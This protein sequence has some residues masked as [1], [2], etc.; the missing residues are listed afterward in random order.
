MRP[1][2]LTAASLA[3]LAIGGTAIADDTER[4][5]DL[6]GF[7]E[8]TVEGVYE[9]VVTVGGDFAITLSGEKKYMA[10]AEVEVDGDRLIL[11]TKNERSKR[12]WKGDAITATISLPSLE[13]VA[14]RGVGSLTASGIDAD[15]FAASLE[16]VGKVELSGSCTDLTASVEGVGAMEARDLECDRV[17]V[18]VEGIGSAVVFAEDEVD[19]SVEGLGSIEVW[20]KPETVTKTKGLMSSVEIH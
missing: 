14:L 7:D 12:S 19:A 3:A 5:Y 11:G 4:S 8:I 13:A 15:D 18:S 6:R 20:G 16:G 17:V 1:A 9:V 10:L 2:T